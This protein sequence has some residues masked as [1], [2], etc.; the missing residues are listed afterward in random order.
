MPAS[1][2]SSAVLPPLAPR[3]KSFAPRAAL[4]G[5]SSRA[6]D[7]AT[8]ASDVDHVAARAASAPGASV[9]DLERDRARSVSFGPFVLERAEGSLWRGDAR[10]PLAPKAFALLDLLLRRAPRLVTKPEI[11]REV[12][13]GTFVTD[14]VV[15]VCIRELRR[16]LDDT[17]KCSRYIQT[18]RARGYRFAGDLAD[19]PGRGDVDSRDGRVDL[20]RL[21]AAL[22]TA[23][24]ATLGQLLGAADRAERDRAWPECTNHLSAACTSAEFLLPEAHHLRAELLLRLMQAAR[25]AGRGTEWRAAVARALALTQQ[26]GDASLHARVVLALADA[27]QAI[28]TVSRELVARLDDAAR[29]LP[30]TE[31]ALL[32]RLRARFAY[33]LYAEP[34][35]SERRTALLRDALDAAHASGC[36][37]TLAHVMK[38]ALWARRGPH[39][40]RE[41]LADA[42]QLAALAA[43]QAEYEPRLHALGLCLE[44]SLEVGDGA[45]FEQAFTAYTAL[46]EK[47]RQPWYTWA[48]LRMR[49]LRALLRD[50]HADAERYIAESVR[51]AQG[52]D[53]SDV[54]ALFYAQTLLLRLQQGRLAEIV[55]VLDGA[56]HLAET[57]PAWGALGIYAR[58][59]CGSRARAQADLEALAAGGFAKI[60]EDTF[61]T[62]A[63]VL[64][65]DACAT[66]GLR[67]VARQLYDRL[68]PHADQLAVAYGMA[69]FGSIH[70]P[71]GRLAALLGRTLAAR[72]HLDAAMHVHDRLGA[73][74]WL[75]QTRI[76]RQ[77]LLDTRRPA[78]ARTDSRPP[79]HARGAADWR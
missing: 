49:V 1:M 47:A 20:P 8:P 35:A 59:H 62:A 2:L 69:C 39:G 53:H 63:M 57:T 14:A 4:P 67:K 26:T 33:A 19:A 70:R 23:P 29:R 11:L 34:D 68:L 21:V 42:E 30:D 54:V 38:Y 15:K 6:I 13:A 52:F 73:A 9:S 36:N 50:A 65:A 18:E 24:A 44:L 45:R 55:P 64:L 31:V 16:A 75:G 56:A 60:P 74:Y 27:H 58:A 17:A 7:A 41:R 51:L 78:R 43:G 48:A 40:A 79:M 25:R 72:R 22:D 46:A 37:A 3:A 10:V 61:F 28:M 76:A 5:P 71:L 32:A 12:W 77:S 66:L